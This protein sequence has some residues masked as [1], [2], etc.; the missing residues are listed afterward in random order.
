MNT[1]KIYE[2]QRQRVLKDSQYKEWVNRD[3]FAAL[4]KK[5]QRFGQAASL[6]AGEDDSDGFSVLGLDNFDATFLVNVKLKPEAG[7]ADESVNDGAVIT[8]SYS[9]H[10]EF[11]QG[12]LK[13]YTA[14]DLSDRRRKRF[15]IMPTS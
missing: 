9:V 1:E 11:E 5:L 10:A 7:R 4:E 12:K 15:V 3:L 14:T 6:G 13:S 8:H 2:T